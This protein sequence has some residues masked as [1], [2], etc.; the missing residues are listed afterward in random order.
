[1][2]GHTRTCGRGARRCNLPRGSLEVRRCW[3]Q[4]SPA[5]HSGPDCGE[6]LQ[7]G[8]EEGDQ[9]SA[10][11][12]ERLHLDCLFGNSSLQLLME[13]FPSE[14]QTADRSQSALLYV[15]HQHQKQPQKRRLQV[16]RCWPVLYWSLR[17]HWPIFFSYLTQIS[18]FR[19]MLFFFL[20]VSVLPSAL[21][22]TG[23]PSK[24]SLFSK[25]VDLLLL[26]RLF[27]DGV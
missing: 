11:V 21:L 17:L 1:M 18:S 13:P 8:G 10:C 22:V 19:N 16:Q 24:S 25:L 20:P 9:N 2:G 27:W 26:L 7:A 6:Q 5:A 12:I 14:E 3:L 15:H 4:R 23:T